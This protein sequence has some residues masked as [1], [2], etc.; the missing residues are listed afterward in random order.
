[1][2]KSQFVKLL[3]STCNAFSSFYHVEI[4]Y[5]SVNCRWF[6]LIWTYNQSDKRERANLPHGCLAI[7]NYDTH[8]PRPIFSNFSGAHCHKWFSRPISL[9]LTHCIC[10]HCNAASIWALSGDSF[11][12]LCWNLASECK[13]L[14]MWGW[15]SHFVKYHADFNR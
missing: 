9:H 11:R 13:L 8:R 2:R 4:Q 1:M 10:S 6:R 5:A 12:Q 15:L 7:T 3:S 14:S